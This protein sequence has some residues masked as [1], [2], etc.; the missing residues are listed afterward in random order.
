MLHGAVNSRAFASSTCLPWVAPRTVTPEQPIPCTT[1]TAVRC[2]TCAC[3]MIGI[4]WQTTSYLKVCP[5]HWQKASAA[6]SEVRYGPNPNGS[7]SYWKPNVIRVPSDQ[8]SCL[9]TAFQPSDSA[10]RQVGLKSISHLQLPEYPMSVSLNGLL[11][12]V[13]FRRD[14]LVGHT[15]PYHLQY[16]YFPGGQRL[17]SAHNLLI[18]IGWIR[19]AKT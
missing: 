9:D 15:F 4:P 10:G 17:D 3:L 11:S 13:E 18:N 7:E 8:G 2:R 14:D 12:D 16:L 6:V 5:L 1:P 19:P